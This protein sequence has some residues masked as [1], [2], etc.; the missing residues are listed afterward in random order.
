[1]EARVS[2]LNLEP[3][4]SVDLSTIETDIINIKSDITSLEAADTSL[5]SR[6]S[7]TELDQSVQTLVSG[8]YVTPTSVVLQQPNTG[9]GFV[10]DGSFNG[11]VVMIYPSGSGQTLTFRNSNFGAFNTLYLG[12]VAMWMSGEWRFVRLLSS[13]SSVNE[14]VIGDGATFSKF[15]S[16]GLIHSGSIT[17]SYTNIWLNNLSGLTRFR[18]NEG[19][20]LITHFEA[21]TNNV[22]D[23]G[24]YEGAGASSLVAEFLGGTL[25]DTHC[26]CKMSG[27]D[28]DWETH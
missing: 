7:V 9:N 1:M 25:V 3:S 14:D 13:S 23:V 26:T 16:P 5:S 18:F 22:V 11:Q 8:T 20:R 10:D 15:A 21:T 24:V 19:P 12:V 17:T 28:R 6:I 2:S 4:G 27:D